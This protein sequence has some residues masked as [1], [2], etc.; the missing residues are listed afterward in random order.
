M[1]N[2]L[3]AARQCA[4]FRYFKSN[5]AIWLAVI[6][7]TRRDLLARLHAEAAV[8][9]IGSVHGLL[10]NGKVGSMGALALVGLASSTSLFRP[11]Q[12]G[13]THPGC[14][15]HTRP[16][17]IRAFCLLDWLSAAGHGQ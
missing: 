9:F 3:A 14:T 11:A 13:T 4:V 2:G 7:F 15:P 8:L 1:T 6:N 10:L 5:E 17:T 16:H 12:S